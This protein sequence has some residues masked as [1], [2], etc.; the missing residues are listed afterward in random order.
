MAQSSEEYWRQRE[1]EQRKK[2]ITDEKEY[3]REINRI[4]ADMMDSIQKEIDNLNDKKNKMVDSTTKEENKGG[5]GLSCYSEVDETNVFKVTGKSKD[6][7]LGLSDS[8]YVTNYD[9]TQFYKNKFIPSLSTRIPNEGTIKIS[10]SINN[11]VVI[12]YYT[13]IER[14]RVNTFSLT[15]DVYKITLNDYIFPEFTVEA[16]GLNN[17]KRPFKITDYYSTFVIKLNA[18]L[19]GRILNGVLFPLEYI[20]KEC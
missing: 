11:N 20:L 12:D 5:V 8:G 6:Y 2:N 3:Q 14:Y 1:E 10:D 4:Y 15:G 17:T 16:T 13:G 19:I 9:E 7:S 18:T